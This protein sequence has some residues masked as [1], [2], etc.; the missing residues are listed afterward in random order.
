M[1]MNI[2]MAFFL[3]GLILLTGCSTGRKTLVKPMKPID[4][5]MNPQARKYY[6]QGIMDEF[7]MDYENA[8]LHYYMA[9]S[10][11]PDNIA[12]T[13]AIAEVQNQLG[14]ND[15][16]LFF[17]DEALSVFPRDRRLLQQKAKVLMQMEDY[18]QAYAIY[19]QLVWEFPQVYYYQAIATRL[20]MMLQ[21]TI[22]L[23]EIY[24]HLA[25]VNNTPDDHVNLGKFY[26][27]AGKFISARDEFRKAVRMDSSNVEAL[28]GLAETYLQTGNV[29]QAYP[30]LE[31]LFI[32]TGDLYYVQKIVEFALQKE[33]YQYL[34]DFL[35]EFLQSHPAEAPQFHLLLAELYLNHRKSDLSLQTLVTYRKLQPE[36]AEAYYSIKARI[37][38]DGGQDSLALVTLDSGLTVFPDSE[39]LTVLKGYALATLKKYENAERWLKQAMNR[40]PESLPVHTLLAQIY[41]EQGRQDQAAEISRTIL[42]LDSTN[43]MAMAFLASFYWQQK[44]H[45]LADS[46][47]QKALALYP[48]DPLLLNNYAYFLCEQNIQL[49]QALEMVNRALEKDRNNPAYLDTKGWILFRLGHY[50]EALDWVRQAYELKPDDPDVT[51]HLGDIYWKLNQPDSARQYWEKALQ[52]APDR[53]NIKSKIENGL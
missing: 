13:V 30:L 4:A 43:L 32:E 5:E 19:K 47:Y 25:S 9:R 22:G 8:L 24:V 50:G 46:I 3:V 45:S 11:D 31:K 27:N 15:V 6:L 39:R 48:D 53:D 23:E 2:T 52:L 42:R 34:Q 10:F 36:P 40:F 28:S 41:M 37:L 18:Q 21:D 26:L 51:D 16:A 38:M 12:L 17:I 44:Q 29:Q 20:A 7:A 35:A 1:K 49:Q 14:M 33:D